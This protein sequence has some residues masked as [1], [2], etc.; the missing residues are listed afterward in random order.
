MLLQIPQYCLFFLI[1]S[2]ISSF[3]SLKVSAFPSIVVSTSGKTF[4][5]CCHNCRFAIGGRTGFFGVIKIVLFFSSVISVVGLEK[6][7]TPGLDGRRAIVG[8]PFLSG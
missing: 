1:K 8:S 6:L 7:S 3:L 4:C 5:N 2:S